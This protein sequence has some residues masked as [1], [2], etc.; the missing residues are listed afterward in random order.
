MS[1]QQVTVEGVT[2]ELPSPSWCSLRR[3]QS[4]SRG[5]T[6][7]RRRSSIV[8]SYAWAS[9][10]RA[11]ST[12][13][14][15]SSAASPGALRRWSSCG[16]RSCDLSRDAG[17]G[18]A[19]ARSTGPRQ[20]HRLFG[21]RDAR[22]S[23]RTGRS[24]PTR[25]PGVTGCVPCPCRSP[26]PRL[27][28]PRGRQGARR[29]VPR[30]PVGSLRAEL[31]VRGTKSSDI[32]A[33]CLAS[34]PTPPTEAEQNAMSRFRP[35]DGPAHVEVGRLRSFRKPRA[36]R[37]VGSHTDPSSSCSGCHSCSG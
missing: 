2:R 14:R 37:R 25:Q 11:P 15:C 12:R 21:G 16:G 10:T 35:D 29:A 31:W 36:V 30:P 18:R 32:V 20:L 28:Y 3:T 23:G 33:E 17:G 5:P 13:P 24:E 4:S 9:V 22:P 7:C 26:R 27:R 8:S 1:E 6:R 19:G 34:V